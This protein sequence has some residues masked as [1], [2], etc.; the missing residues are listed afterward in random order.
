MEEGKRRGAER[1]PE[2]L[3]EQKDAADRP[4][5]E[6]EVLSAGTGEQSIKV[7]SDDADITEDR[8]KAA[9]KVKIESP[10]IKIV[11]NGQTSTTSSDKE[12]DKGGIQLKAIRV[13]MEKEAQRGGAAGDD[14][15]PSINNNDNSN[16]PDKL[17]KQ[18]SSANQPPEEFKGVKEM[19]EE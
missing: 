1:A 5:S 11:K 7:K 14:M 8:D 6:R 3:A 10:V 17:I 4:D 16:S 15:S 19:T 13:Q 12:R 9:A 2:Q 18:N